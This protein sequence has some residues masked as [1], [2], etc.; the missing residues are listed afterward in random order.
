MAHKT[1]AP[2]SSQRRLMAIAITGNFLLV[3]EHSPQQARRPPGRWPRARTGRRKLSVFDR[4]ISTLGCGRSSAR[5][6]AALLGCARQWSACGSLGAREDAQRSV[7]RTVQWGHASFRRDHRSGG[8]N[9]AGDQLAG[10]L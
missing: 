5:P 3:Y 7:E 1:A 6:Y 8:G 2:I 9:A 4:A 10:A